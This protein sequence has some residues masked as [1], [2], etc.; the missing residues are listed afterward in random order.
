MLLGP[1]VGP[2][3]ESSAQA[4]SVFLLAPQLAGSRGGV[5]GEGVSWNRRVSFADLYGAGKI[6]AR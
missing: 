3:A 4:L 1:Q 6:D 5:R 2:H